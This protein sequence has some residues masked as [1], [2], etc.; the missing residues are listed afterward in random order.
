MAPTG[1]TSMNTQNWA[2]LGLAFPKLFSLHS[3][4]VL[5]RELGI[6]TQEAAGQ[7]EH[8]GKPSASSSA[9]G[10]QICTL[11]LDNRSSK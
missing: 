1:D 6:A 9:P 11:S 5:W 4:N 2:P 7:L 10:K 8:P 3:W